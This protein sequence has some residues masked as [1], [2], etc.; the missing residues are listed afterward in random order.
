M[1]WAKGSQSAT[2]VNPT[3]NIGLEVFVNR[4]EKKKKKKRPKKGLD[5]ISY[6]NSTGL[7]LHHRY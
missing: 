5:T 2:E 4:L 7:V 1:P 3:P 6:H